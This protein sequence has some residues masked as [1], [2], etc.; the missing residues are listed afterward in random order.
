MSNSEP[1]GLSEGTMRLELAGVSDG[2]LLVRCEGAVDLPGYRS[3]DDPLAR[4]LGPDVYSSQVLLDMEKATYLDTTAVGWLVGCHKRFRE[5]GGRLVLFALPPQ[6]LAVVRLLQLDRVL[7][8]A[9]DLPAA[10]AALKDR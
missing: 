8:L 7:D 5:A 2:V 3:A 10:R 9:D 1:P 6:V 4:L